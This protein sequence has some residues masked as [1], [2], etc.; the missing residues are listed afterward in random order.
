MIKFEL[1]DST[2]QTSKRYW[3]E[4]K[5]Q[6]VKPDDL[7]KAKF[8]NRFLFESSNLN[9]TNSHASSSTTTTITPIIPSLTSMTQIMSEIDKELKIDEKNDIEV[10]TQE[11]ETTTGKK[12]QNKQL[13]QFIRKPV[14]CM[15]GCI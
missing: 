15:H 13:K 4:L 14:K 2:W 11:Q 1:S 7:K 6:F 10:K 8:L 9:N 5:K 3:N 12:L